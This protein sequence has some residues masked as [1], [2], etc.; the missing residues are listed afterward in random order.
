LRGR[1][2]GRCARIVFGCPLTHPLP[3]AGGGRG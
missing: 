3:P 2:G 1:P